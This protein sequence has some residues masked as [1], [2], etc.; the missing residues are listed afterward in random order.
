M[1]LAART[2]LLNNAS[3]CLS[4]SLFHS[5]RTLATRPHTHLKGKPT[6]TTH[7]TT[8]VVV[9]IESIQFTILRSLCIVALWCLN[10]HAKE[11][12]GDV[13]KWKRENVLKIE[14]ACFVNRSLWRKNTKEL[15][16]ALSDHYMSSVCVWVWEKVRGIEREREFTDARNELKG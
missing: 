10:E 5:H 11:E 9:I 6:T 16:K 7:C 15:W 1:R 3:K 4:L 14:N 12:R 8:D 2:L 13:C